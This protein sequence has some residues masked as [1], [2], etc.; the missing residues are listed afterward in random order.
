MGFTWASLGRWTSGRKQST[1]TST[2]PFRHDRTGP[3]TTTAAWHY[4][5]D[6]GQNAPRPSSSGSTVTE[7]SE[8]TV[9][10]YGI[11]ETEACLRGES[12]L[13]LVALHRQQKE[14]EQRAK[15]GKGKADAYLKR[16]ASSSDRRRDTE[17]RE[18]QWHRQQPYSDE[19]AGDENKDGDVEE[20]K[21]Q[22]RGG[23][24][25]FVEDEDGANEGSRSSWRRT[26]TGASSMEGDRGSLPTLP[27]LSFP[28]L[29]KMVGEAGLRST[30]EPES[31]PAGHEE[32]KC[33][34]ESLL[35]EIT[36]SAQIPSD[37]GGIS[38]VW[39]EHRGWSPRSMRR[40]VDMYR[41]PS[42]DFE[43]S[44]NDNQ[45][46]LSE[47][48]HYMP[49][50]HTSLGWYDDGIKT[51]FYDIDLSDPESNE[52][53]VEQPPDTR[54]ERAVR[55]PI[56]KESLPHSFQ[57]RSVSRASC[58]VETCDN[59]TSEG[60]RSA[61]AYPVMS[62]VIS[63]TSDFLWSS[64]EGYRDLYEDTGE[65]DLRNEPESPPRRLFTSDGDFEYSGWGPDNSLND[66]DGSPIAPVSKWSPTET[67]KTIDELLDSYVNY[68]DPETET[69]TF[70][71]A[72]EAPTLPCP[73]VQ[74]VDL[75]PFYAGTPNALAPLVIVARGLS[76]PPSTT[77]AETQEHL[78][79]N[80]NILR[81]LTLHCIPAPDI[82]PVEHITDLTEPVLP[83]PQ[84]HAG[85][86]SRHRRQEYTRLLQAIRSLHW[87]ADTINDM[88]AVVDFQPPRRGA[89]TA[90]PMFRKLRATDAERR[91]CL[92]SAQLHHLRQHG[93]SM[94]N[95]LQ[96]NDVPRVVS[97]GLGP[98]L[99]EA[100]E[101]GALG[102]ARDCNILEEQGAL[103]E[104]L[105]DPDDVAKPPRG[106][107][108]R[109]DGRPSGLRSCVGVDEDDLHGEEA[110][111]R[112]DEGGDHK[113]G[114]VPYIVS[115]LFPD[116][117]SGHTQWDQREVSPVATS[118]RPGELE[119]LFRDAQSQSSSS[120]DGPGTVNTADAGVARE[121]MLKRSASFWVSSED[122]TV[123]F[124]N[125]M[126]QKSEIQRFF[127]DDG[128][129][130]VVAGAGELES[131]AGQQSMQDEKSWGADLGGMLVD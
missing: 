15:S 109:H 11:E 70:P 75:P 124:D 7:H 130:L 97:R 48:C 19:V 104:L 10:P 110:L 59:A 84:P 39:N 27:T 21:T 60:D 44:T 101:S 72:P 103:L 53:G 50:S 78:A 14:A 102:I 38:D 119:T 16:A 89:A 94:L 65:D 41:S 125:E 111:F 36:Q 81:Y 23:I 29:G 127:R 120:S 63:D 5:P 47:A 122:N 54:R 56:R 126:S 108:R 67:D 35:S 58:L 31:A 95:V 62:A 61:E 85:F 117:S 91:G 42:P 8:F 106:G 93:V 3:A 131:P 22:T 76:L 12:P 99:L 32:V 107:K 20:V 52:R 17:I 69:D 128:A 73:L 121:N 24:A 87:T 98:R 45:E 71:V 118:S 25:A 6:G 116:G 40:L 114:D 112:G 34:T 80:A 55:F 100:A 28:E 113:S 66:Q 57:I 92:T 123:L 86:P 4:S 96:M 37:L 46:E 79:R 49:R 83:H 74:G 82:N 2:E 26:K 88:L 43:L 64:T 13:A 51:A 33:L 129:D 1:T 105:V 18:R 30:T 68:S 77:Y 90:L 115:P 9:R